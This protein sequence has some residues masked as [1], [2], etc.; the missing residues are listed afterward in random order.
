MAGSFQLDELSKWL[1]DA[2]HAL[3][4]VDHQDGEWVIAS[5]FTFDQLL[6]LIQAPNLVSRRRDAI[7]YA[8]VLQL[9]GLLD[10]DDSG[11]PYDDSSAALA[12]SALSKFVRDNWSEVMRIERDMGFGASFDT[13]VV[14]YV[15]TFLSGQNVKDGS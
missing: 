15:T 13:F 7:L 3:P 8:L 4:L 5:A 1:T 9:E 12:L 6:P 11:E 2:D 10:P 14:P